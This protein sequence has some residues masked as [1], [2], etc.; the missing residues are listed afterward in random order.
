MGSFDQLAKEI[1][2]EEDLQLVFEYIKTIKFGTVTLVIQN[3]KL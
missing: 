3:G 1:I 2:S